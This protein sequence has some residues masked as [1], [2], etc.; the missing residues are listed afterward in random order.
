MH[1]VS[2]TRR[3]DAAQSRLQETS[4]NNDNEQ[5]EVSHRASAIRSL[6]RRQSGRGYTGCTVSPGNVEPAGPSSRQPPALEYYTPSDEE[7]VSGE[8][9]P[10]QMHS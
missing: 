5:A 10:A 2:H 3:R 4:L 9:Q 7:C 1:S 8:G 6:G